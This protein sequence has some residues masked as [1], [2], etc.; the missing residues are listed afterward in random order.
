MSR[1]SVKAWVRAH[2]PVAL[3]DDDHTH[4]E[5]LVA[6]EAAKR[7]LS[8]DDEA[9]IQLPGGSTFTLS[10]ADAEQAV[11][12]LLDVRPCCRVHACACAF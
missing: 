4:A 1:P 12:P 9:T 7:R 11:T 6:V 3:P 8:A 5:L 10:V 2:T